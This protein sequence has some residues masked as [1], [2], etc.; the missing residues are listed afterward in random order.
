MEGETEGIRISISVAGYVSMYFGRPL[1]WQWIHVPSIT[2]LSGASNHAEIM[3]FADVQAAVLPQLLLSL[4]SL[5]I[6]LSRP[7]HVALVSYSLCKVSTGS[8]KRLPNHRPNHL[9]CEYSHAA[10]CK[11][12]ETK[13]SYCSSYGRKVGPLTGF[14]L[15][16]KSVMFTGQMAQQMTLPWR[17]NTF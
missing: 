9:R 5:G 6:L 7:S 17:R 2:H 3:I 4:L 1:I 13:V 12:G 8:S 15:Y 16:S 10:N 11:Q 14:I